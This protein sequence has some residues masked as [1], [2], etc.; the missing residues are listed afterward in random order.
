MLR[1]APFGSLGDRQSRLLLRLQR[2][3]L[4]QARAR[5]NWAVADGEPWERKV[6]RI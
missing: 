4:L 3:R 2:G 5:V 1:V 6:T